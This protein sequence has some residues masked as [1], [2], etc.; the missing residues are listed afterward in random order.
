MFFRRTKRQV[1]PV[2]VDCSLLELEETVSDRKNHS[3][4]EVDV[5]NKTNASLVLKKN[6]SSEDLSLSPKRTLSPQKSAR[7][8]DFEPLSPQKKS[9]ARFDFKESDSAQSFQCFDFDSS[10]NST[11]LAKLQTGDEKSAAELVRLVNKNEVTALSLIDE[12][13][14]HVSLCIMRQKNTS[15][16]D[17]KNKILA[18]TVLQAI[19]NVDDLDTILARTDLVPLLL[20]SI[21]SSKKDSPLPYH[22]LSNLAAD[23]LFHCSCSGD[24]YSQVLQDFRALNVVLSHIM[25]HPSLFS[26]HESMIS[27]LGN[28]A[29]DSQDNSVVFESGII[30]RLVD[31]L[32]YIVE[33]HG[34][35]NSFNGARDRDATRSIQDKLI[36]HNIIFAVHNFASVAAYEEDLIQEGAIRFLVALLGSDDDDEQTWGVELHMKIEAAAALLNLCVNPLSAQ[37]LENY[38]VV[39]VLIS[40]LHR[41]SVFIQTKTEEG[42]RAPKGTQY[43]FQEDEDEPLVLLALTLGTLK[44]LT[45]TKANMNVLTTEKNI[46]LFLQLEKISYPEVQKKAKYFVVIMSKYLNERKEIIKSEDND[47]N[48]MMI[49]SSFEG[50]HDDGEEE[51][52]GSSSKK[53][54][55][56]AAK[57][58]DLM[59]KLE[60]AAI[61]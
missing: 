10:H 42:E 32:R 8:F 2:A 24:A 31:A 20:S 30:P 46:E 19:G 47:K 33:S 7:F 57:F 26:V 50:D 59:M 35:S 58:D 4:D 49:G 17:V 18:L 48:Q 60:A 55:S 36:I 12:G 29:L 15:I 39:N 3:A 13:L 1:H 22:E 9:T 44:S 16:D 34:T 37:D 25:E 23:I 54:S 5:C 41:A 14:L 28:L 53:L 45:L 52:K 56:A 61:M 51:E 40:T 43:D 6:R 38:Q 21:R 11:L 27:T